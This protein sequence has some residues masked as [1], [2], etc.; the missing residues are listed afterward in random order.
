MNGEDRAW[1]QARFDRIEDRIE[2]HRDHVHG[3]LRALEGWRSFAAGAAALIGGFFGLAGAW[4][5]R[6]IGGE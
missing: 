1:L 5:S 4:L 6:I 3:R 2:A